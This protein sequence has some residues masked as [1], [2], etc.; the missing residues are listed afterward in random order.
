[1]YPDKSFKSA[2]YRI[3][4]WEA[5]RKAVRHESQGDHERAILEC[6][7]SIEFH[8]T[9]ECHT[10]MGWILSHKGDY[11]EGIRQCRK[12]IELDPDYGNPYNDIGAYLI[13]LGHE[14]EAVPWLEQARRAARYECRHYPLFNLGRV[15][16]RLGRFGD[17]RRHFAEALFMRPG[18]AMAREALQRVICGYN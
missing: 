3:L 4:A 1:M 7:R 2:G 5:L 17:A 8:P 12:A 11:R 13:E 16:E 18:F 6:Q 15:S 9:A 14:R 10:F